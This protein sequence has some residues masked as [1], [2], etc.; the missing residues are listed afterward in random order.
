MVELLAP[1]GSFANLQAAINAGADSVYFGI[2]GINM[3]AGARADFTLEN[4]GE[5]VS[6]CHSAGIR[7]YLTVNTII[8]EKEYDLIKKILDKAEEVKVDAIIAWDLFV[9]GE[10]KRRGM[11]CHLSTQASVANFEALKQYY[12]LFALRRFVLARELDL[13]QIKTIIKRCEEEN[14]DAEI[15]TFIHGA[16]CISVSGRCFMSQ[17]AHCKSANRGECLQS[18]RRSYL[19]KDEEEGT[20]FK[21][22]NN[23]V[24][25]PKDLSVMPIFEKILDSG[26]KVLKIEGR[27]RSPEYVKVVVESYREAIDLHEKNELSEEKKKELIE[28][29]QTVYNRGF[30]TGFY[31]GKPMHAW[32]GTYGSKA[33]TKKIRLGKVENYYTDKKIACVKIEQNEISAGDKYYIIGPTTGVIEAEL[34]SMFV[35]EKE[36]KKAKQGDEITFKTSKCRKGDEM[37]KIEENIN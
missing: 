17:I 9:L 32:A 34:E 20:E 30:E 11:E 10:C 21:L 5:V 29:M 25:S 35:N 1:A 6:R 22:E 14:L 7:A 19:I 12:E 2:R 37:F 33:T 24:M 36:G 26:V 18:C 3:R 31:L 13:E 8:Y 16:M 15:E 28:K 4:M 27:A 23:F